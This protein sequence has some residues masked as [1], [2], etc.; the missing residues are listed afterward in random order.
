MQPLGLLVASIIAISQVMA[1]AMSLLALMSLLAAAALPAGK[2]DP[3][4]PDGMGLENC[5]NLLSTTRNAVCLT[6]QKL[7]NE[8]RRLTHYPRKSLIV[9]LN[10]QWT[11]MA[12]V[13]I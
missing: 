12:I 5:L 9:N 8:M 1:R 6:D 3:G 4:S 7:H 11:S 10:T 13:R 2:R